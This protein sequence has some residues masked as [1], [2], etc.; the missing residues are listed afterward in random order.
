MHGQRRLWIASLIAGAILWT[1]AWAR[2]DEGVE[3]ALDKIRK[4][5]E[6]CIIGADLRLRHEH[7]FNHLTLIDDAPDREWSYERYRLRLWTSITPLKDQ[8]LTA[9]VRLCTE[10][11][12]WWLPD[13]RTEWQWTDVLFDE[14][15]VTWNKPGGLPLGVTVGRQNFFDD[16]TG[17]YNYGDGWLLGDGTPLDGSRTFYFDAINV[18]FDL[19]DMK[20]TVNVAYIDQRAKPVAALHPIGNRVINLT[21]QDERGGFVWISNKS[22]PDMTVEPYFIYNNNDAELPGGYEGD[23]YTVGLRAE[24]PFSPN[25]KAKAQGCY[26]WGQRNGED[27]SAFAFTARVGYAFNDGMKNQLYA[28]YEV[29]SGDDPDTAKVEAFDPLWGRWPQ[30]SELLIYTWILETRVSEITN[31]HRVSLG[32][33]CAPIADMSV[34]V[35]YSAL[36]AL[37]NTL[38][39]SPV[40][41]DS[42]KF[43]GHLLRAILRYT[44]SRHL[45]AHLWIE[46]FIPGSYYADDRED[47]ATFLRLQAVITL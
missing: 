17:V 9:N 39:G 14:L 43:R 45:N 11:R 5:V 6:G 19:V 26:Q 1:A 15:N 2:A 35:D 7:L 46:H 37:Q 27:I 3:A 4:P 21:E 18:R 32:W 29:M 25:I 38:A 24:R 42:G 47:A 31:F 12:H 16:R 30:W 22:I 36:F 8:E 33:T 34:V 20:T 13:S 10:N 23:V 41:D 28:V 40:F 44:F